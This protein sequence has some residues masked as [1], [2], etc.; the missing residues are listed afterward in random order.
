[1]ALWVY[2][3]QANSMDASE[4]NKTAY[5]LGRKNRETGFTLIEVMI[6]VAIIGI[7]G[8]LAIPS[9]ADWKAQHDLREAVS[10]IAS[11]LNLARA[12]A[13]NRNRQATVTIQLSPAGVVQISG[14][15]ILTPVPLTT[16]NIFP[17]ETMNGNVTGLPGGTVNVVFSSMGLS[18]STVNQT[19]QIAN[20]RGLVYSLVVT[21]SGKVTWC[22]TS[23][24]P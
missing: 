11:N 13:M 3:E 19:I 7:T 17:P 23:T 16:L 22:T 10:E 5:M 9:F 12:V 20:T 2:L 24:C 21:P 14:V 4:Q 6:V 1:M 8:A 15:T 18:T